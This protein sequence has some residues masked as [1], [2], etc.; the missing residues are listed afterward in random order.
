M[1]KTTTTI[2]KRNTRMK[3]KIVSINATPQDQGRIETIRK[4][5]CDI[6]ELN[7]LAG[8]VSTSDAIKYAL[9]IANEHVKNIKNKEQN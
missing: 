5:I 4:H 7:Q 2:I 3:A 1:T 8:D 6:H 9:L